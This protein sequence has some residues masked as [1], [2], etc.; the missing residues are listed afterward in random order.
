M[1]GTL[2]SFADSALLSRGL[3]F[4]SFASALPP[5]AAKIFWKFWAGRGRVAGSGATEACGSVALLS[6]ELRDDET[7]W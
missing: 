2:L 7:E 3:V 6:N 4:T 1:E 5:E